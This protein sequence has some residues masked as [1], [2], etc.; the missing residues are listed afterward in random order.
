MLLETTTIARARNQIC[1]LKLRTRVIVVTVC[2]RKKSFVLQS[3]KKMRCKNVSHAT[4]KSMRKKSQ[5]FPLKKLLLAVNGV[6][7]SKQ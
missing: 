7:R 6:T 4:V 1:G 5:T 2:V 3:E